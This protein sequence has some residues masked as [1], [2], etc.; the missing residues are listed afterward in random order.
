MR[1]RLLTSR[2]IVTGFL[3]VLILGGRSVS[4][5]YEEITVISGGTV[6]GRVVLKGTPPPSRQRT[7]FEMH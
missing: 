7:R 1:S 5:G 3:C 2:I 4:W 6:T